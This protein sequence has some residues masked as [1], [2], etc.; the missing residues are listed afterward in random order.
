VAFST[1]GAQLA[2]GGA[3]GTIRLWDVET[4]KELRRMAGHTAG[5]ENV[6]FSPDGKLIAS[7]G[8]D[9]LARLWDADYHDT[10]RYLCSRLLRDFTDDERT[11]Y[12]I[13]DDTPTCPEK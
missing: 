2:S 13:E 9:G 3:D 6:I 7:A 5:V 12:N 4:G 10:M 8:D 1:D 11:Q